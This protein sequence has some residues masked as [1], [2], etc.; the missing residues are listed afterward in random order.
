MTT[1]LS[2]MCTR[3]GTS[4]QS[5]YRAGTRLERRVLCGCMFGADGAVI[6]GRVGSTWYALPKPH[7][8]CT[9]PGQKAT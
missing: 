8:T 5:L 1:M 3:S 6:G 9:R 7:G 4:P 2:R